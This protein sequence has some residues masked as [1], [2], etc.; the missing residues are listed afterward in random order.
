[1]VRPF[2]IRMGRRVWFHTTI[3]M[4]VH[5]LESIVSEI[6]SKCSDNFQS[7]HAEINPKVPMGNFTK[8]SVETIYL[9]IAGMN[10][11]YGARNV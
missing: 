3:L 1:M 9:L 4:Q 8:M 5:N 7:G 10:T 2:S 11:P 6:M